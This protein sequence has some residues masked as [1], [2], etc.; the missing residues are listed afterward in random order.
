MQ[1]A[2]GSTHSQI[3]ALRTKSYALQSTIIPSL[4]HPLNFGLSQWDQLPPIF[5]VLA[6][7]GLWMN[8]SQLQS[9]E[10]G[11]EEPLPVEVQFS[12]TEIPIK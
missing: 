6:D 12:A 7:G 1:H 11:K 4:L 5:S 8:A 9:M 2:L 10:A 3:S